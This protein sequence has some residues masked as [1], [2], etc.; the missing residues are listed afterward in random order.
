[1]ADEIKIFIGADTSGVEEG[2]GKI[3]TESE[4]LERSLANLTKISSV[5]FALLTTEAV[6]ALK[7]F[8]EQD[9]ATRQLNTSLQNQ[10]IFSK[11]L[12]DDYVK[13]AGNLQAL[14]G[15]GDEA[16]IKGQGILQSFIGQQKQTE[17]LN[18]S[19]LD[20]A[21]GLG[22]DT[23]QAYEL[24]GK[25]IGTSTNALG[26]Y[27]IQ[28]DDS[29]SQQEKM[30]KIIEISNARFSGQA[31][32]ANQGLGGILGMKNAFG[33]IQE[34]IGA[35]LAPV[36]GS[37]IKLMTNLFM[38]IKDNKGLMDLVV[39]LGIAAAAVTGLIITLFGGATAFLAFKNSAMIAQIAAL[40][41][42]TGVKAAISATGIGL[43]IILAT[44]LV[45]NWQ[46]RL[47]QLQA[48]FFAFSNQIAPLMSALGG[49]LTG[50][51]TLN[52]SQIKENWNNLKAVLSKGA[53]DY[54]QEL[55]RIKS[56]QE[57]TLGP[58]QNESLKK[59]ADQ[60]NKDQ[61][62]RDAQMRESK[63]LHYEAM[64]LDREEHS[65]VLIQLVQQE[66]DLLKQI[67]EEQNIK[68]R[69]ALQLKYDE[70]RAMRVEQEVLDNE[71]RTV[72]QDELLAQNEEFQA[73]SEE[74]KAAFLEQ[75]QGQLSVQI[76][77]EKSTKQ[78]A[79]LA[80]LKEDIAR[81]NQFLKDEEKFGTAYAIINSVM[82]SAVFTG[83]KQAFGE[84]AA[85][86]QSS[87]STLKGIGKVAAIA[88][89]IIKT[90]ESAMN[91]YNGFST[92]P[93]VGPALGIAGAAAAV[94]FGTEQ[95]QKVNSAAAGGIMTGG[96]PG[97][98]S[99]PAMLM[100][101]ELVVPTRNF[102]DVVNAVASRQ[103]VANAQGGDNQSFDNT[104]GSSNVSLIVGFDGPEAQQVITLRQN[105]SKSLGTYRGF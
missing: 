81:R 75:N 85:L 42:G 64:R 45:L 83:S 11:S 9:K 50:A 101:G 94:A 56:A 26:R 32:A 95:V 57:D 91:I 53:D 103:N 41:F 35:R 37:L 1:V 100:P 46:T 77:T 13:M 47:T 62:D 90:A 2:L 102:N 88:N 22:V 76:E 87:N 89:I 59:A 14:T 84:L 93:F 72:F 65:G 10:G 28:L 36:V 34:E 52:I 49:I 31:A 18:Q 3:K 82:H 44:D 79:V 54:K 104:G 60:R 21:A 30:N 92:I 7:A 6:F 4:K 8:E 96:T 73:L 19:V 86:T 99:I 69:E 63:T 67:S 27:G 61:S 105:E 5:A 39:G 16:I 33:D 66:S 80:S 17:Q 29:M 51:F 12:S 70:V 55:D 25:S 43:L 71:Q 15:V 23:T 68:E 48:L 20:L 74:Q 24:V 40:A 97:R 78:K 38:I 98:D 58:P